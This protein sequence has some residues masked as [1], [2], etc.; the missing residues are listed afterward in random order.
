M[1]IEDVARVCHEANRAYCLALGDTS[2]VGWDD[3]PAWQR[4]SAI[5]GVKFKINNPDAPASAQHDSWLA[6][7]LAAGWKWGSVKDA[8]KKD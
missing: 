3:A 5:T 6:Q 8:D 4:E 7:K 2:H 1:T